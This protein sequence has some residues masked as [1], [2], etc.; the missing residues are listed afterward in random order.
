[1]KHQI[2]PGERT[3]ESHHNRIADAYFNSTPGARRARAVVQ[4]RQGNW[5]HQ[6]RTAD[7]SHGGALPKLKKGGGQIMPS[8]EVKNYNK[9]ISEMGFPHKM[10]GIHEVN[11]GT[12]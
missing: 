2:G 6:S 12:E 7:Y 4:R 1:M 9:L 3:V 11:T 5:S 10:I 8:R